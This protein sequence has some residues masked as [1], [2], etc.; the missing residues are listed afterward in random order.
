MRAHIVYAGLLWPLTLVRFVAQR[1]E[2]VC[3][4]GRV[5]DFS[6][7]DNYIMRWGLQHPIVSFEVCVGH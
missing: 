2:K 3:L 4:S 5:L 1:V 6:L 7:L